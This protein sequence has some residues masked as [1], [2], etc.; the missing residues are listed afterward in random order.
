MSRR[1]RIA[2]GRYCFYAGV[3]RCRLERPPPRLLSGS[4]L[5]VPSPRKTRLSSRLILVAQITFLSLTAA[6]LLRHTVYVGLREDNRRNRFGGDVRHGRACVKSTGPP[7]TLTNMRRNG[8][9]AA[10]FASLNAP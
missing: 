2:G 6:G 9:R 4:P 1:A 3:S 7:I 8:V 10:I 5:N